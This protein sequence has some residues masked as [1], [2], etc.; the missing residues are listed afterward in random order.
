MTE[1]EKAKAWREKAGLTLAQLA[2]LTGYAEISLRWFEKGQT[3]PL[4]LAKSGREHDRSISPYVWRR[5]RMACAGVDALLRS[6]R[7][8]DW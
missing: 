8:F 1:H 6:G 5:Y 3:P 7:E 4:R 2:E